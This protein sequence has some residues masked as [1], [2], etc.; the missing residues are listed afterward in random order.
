MATSPQ[1]YEQLLAPLENA[2]GLVRRPLSEQEIQALEREIGLPAPAGV[3]MWLAKVGLLQ[4]VS[5]VDASDFELH[6]EPADAVQARRHILELLGQAGQDL[7]P[8]G[9]DGAGD[10][11]AVRGDD[12]VFID[13]ERR[14]TQ[15]HG[16]FRDWIVAVVEEAV[17]RAAEEPDV[18]KFWCVQFSFEATSEQPIFD[19]LKTISDVQVPGKQWLQKPTTPAGV[20]PAKL[21]FVFLG[22]GRLM[23]R[24]TYKGWSSPHYSFDYE[25][26]VK[27]PAEKSI[28][29]R[30][31]ALFSSRPELKYQLVDYGPLEW[32]PHDK[33]ESPSDVPASDGK[34]WWKFW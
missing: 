9:H 16:S 6:E 17:A 25:E 3:R 24:S 23:S 22:Q 11:I 18:E 1:D 21:A 7:F 5:T 31:D 29:R 26:P 20:K 34:P 2:P 28:I 15:V 30:L 8:F 12:L 14:T 19:A 13:H 27:T 10:E 33:G 4:D 32:P